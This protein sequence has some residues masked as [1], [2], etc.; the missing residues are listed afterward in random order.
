M[1]EPAVGDSTRVRRHRSDYAY[2][3]PQYISLDIPCV[4]RRQTFAL[5]GRTFRVAD[6]GLKAETKHRRPGMR[7][8]LGP[9]RSAWESH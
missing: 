2:Q 8:G 1:G 4:R 7:D 5:N 9:E 3:R 6:P